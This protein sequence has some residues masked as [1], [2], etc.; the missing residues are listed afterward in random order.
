M[1]HELKIDIKREGNYAVVSTEGYINHHNAHLLASECDA[2]MD[3]GVKYLI[4]NLERSRMI[5]SMGIAVLINL[6]ERL[7]KVGGKLY[8][9]HLTPVIERTFQIMGLTQYAKIFPDEESA[10][11]AL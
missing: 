7:L 1:Q 8:F 2:L 5:N 9:C 11:A 3:D 10:T 6:L 4:V